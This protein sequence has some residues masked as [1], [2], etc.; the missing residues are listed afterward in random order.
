MGLLTIMARRF[1]AGQTIKQAMNAVKSLNAQ[2]IMA[3]IDFLGEDVKSKQE[4]TAAADEYLRLL[5]AIDEHK[6]NSNV[7]LK[8]TMMGLEI[9]SEFC[10]ENVKRI[11]EHAAGYNN[12]VRIDME[13]S[14]VTQVT[15]DIF[16]RLREQ[17]SN[18]GIV[19]QAYLY[20]TEKDAEEI[21]AKGYNVRLCKGAY[22]EPAEI[23]F[24]KKEEVNENYIK[25]AKILL[26][27]EGKTA[28]ATHD[29]KM[30]EPLKE[31]IQE[32][33]IAREKYE[34]QMLYGIERKLQ[35]E[36][37]KQGEAVRV[38][39]P[40]GNDWLGYFSRRMMERKENFLFAVRHFL[41]G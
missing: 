3:T 28:I 17:Y 41:K 39:V 18:V 29:R 33:Q 22:K 38:Y 26:D 8:L 16:K 9:D 32:N 35:A 13:G 15:L 25:L 21:S 24:P 4:A 10:F 19:L 27:G 12:F 23:A 6:V 31:Y 2:N 30:I 14:P 7:S 20:R 37:A 5:D 34:W 1:V 40:Y 11:V 36:L